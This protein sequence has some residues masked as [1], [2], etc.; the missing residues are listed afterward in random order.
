MSVPLRLT[1]FTIIIL[2]IFAVAWLVGSA[3]DISPP[4]AGATSAQD[5]APMTHQGGHQ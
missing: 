5:H 4:G 1:T 2:A 3:L